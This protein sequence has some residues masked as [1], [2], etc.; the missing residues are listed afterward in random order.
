[1]L[2]MAYIVQTYNWN[3][4]AII[5]LAYCVGAFIGHIQWVLVHEL[6]H[7]LVME[8][9]EWNTFLLLVSNLS[10]IIPSAVSFRYHHR[11]HHA[12]L[13][14]TYNDMDVPSLFEDK[15]FGH[16]I[17]G[18]ATWLSFFSVLQSVRTLRSPQPFEWAL[19][20]NV[21]GNVTFSIWVI[22]ALGG[23]AFGFLLLSSLLSIGLLL[24]PLGARWIAEHWAVAPPQETYSY[25][26]PINKVAMNIGY[27]NE[28]HDFSRIP[29]SN[30]PKLKAIAP[31]FYEAL[32]SHSS[33]VYLI[34]AFIMDKRF[35]LRSRVVRWPKGYVEKEAK[36]EN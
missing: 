35:T 8:S 33:Y 30:L 16:S 25:Y 28:H 2:G 31:E 36:K 9:S 26:G 15:I 17:I 12:Y 19:V 5:L 34:W 32:H 22:Y 4:L 29:W 13:N 20:F 7:D 3:W 23:K 14:E 27:H 1:M 24:H 11:N 18:K 10:H 6:T 21:V